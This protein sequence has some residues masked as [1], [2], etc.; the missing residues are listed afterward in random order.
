MLET[1]G[2]P[3]RAADWVAEAVAGGD[4]IMGFGHAI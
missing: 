3:D 4:R 1:I 2:S